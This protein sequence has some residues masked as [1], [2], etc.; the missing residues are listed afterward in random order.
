MK[1]RTIILYWFFLLVPTALIC[2]GA[3]RLLRHERER[4]EA[5]ARQAALEQAEAVADSLL[6]AVGTTEDEL[7]DSLRMM[8]TTEPLRAL[9]DWERSN[10]LV[11][12]VFV[13]QTDA[14]LIYPHD[15]VRST[16][17]ERRFRERYAALFA[18][19]IPWEVAGTPVPDQ[20]VPEPIGGRELSNQ[21]EPRVAPSQ[22]KASSYRRNLSVLRELKSVS[23]VA[24]RETYRQEA[25]YEAASAPQVAQAPARMQGPGSRGTTNGG[26]VLADNQGLA[27]EAPAAAPDDG[28][29]GEISGWAKMALVNSPETDRAPAESERAVFTGQAID[30]LAIPAP[31]GVIEGGWI[32]WYS[33]NR[34]SLLGWTQL[35]ARDRVIGIELEFMSLLSRLVTLMPAASPGITMALV[36]GDGHLVTQ[37]GEVEIEPGARAEISIDLDPLLP[38]W[39]IQVFPEDGVFAAGGSLFFLLSGLLL[40]TFVA[41]ILVG[42]TLLTLEARRSFVDSQRK[43]SFVSNVSHELKTP[44]TSIRMYA[45]LLSENRVTDPDKRSNYLDVIASES[46][47]LTRLVNNVLDFSRLEQ[48]RKTY[49]LEPIEL[50]AFTRQVVDAYRIRIE[51]AGLRLTLELPGGHCM[52]KAD[53]DA[54]EQVI[55]NLVDNAIKYAGDGGELRIA[56]ECVTDTCRIRIMDRGP[57]VPHAHRQ[58]IF[59]TFHR[60][61]D[62]LTA[63]RPGSGLGLSIARA[64]MRDLGGD[65]LYAPREGGGSCFIVE[66]PGEDSA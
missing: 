65:L 40:L 11:R 21:L 31:R 62:S 26:Q 17:E 43:T 19:R 63:T 13:W 10:P 64:M 8:P 5:Q 34:L 36:D 6:L 46:Q 9:L 58:R 1:R 48:G 30:H 3:T 57:G 56:L 27:A 50:D 2:L 60:V 49:R 4:L 52:I 66:L 16:D 42:S 15:D 37:R 55:L 7:L 41:A 28:R 22:D 18:G 20:D 51:D 54:L 61:D 29:A 24:S 59:E 44:L 12:H 47:R 53:Q 35:G 39:R 38:H 23:R 14:G 32:P 45:E 25:A 33:D